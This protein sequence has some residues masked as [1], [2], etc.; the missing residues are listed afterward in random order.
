[1]KKS[2]ILLSLIMACTTQLLP[3]KVGLVLSGGGAK[4]AAHLGVIR[5]LEENNIPIDYVTGTSIGA[6]VGA[7]YATGW[8]P[9]EVLDLMLS[10][11]FG[12]WQTGK[13]EQKNWYFFK[14]PPPTPEFAKFNIQLGDSTKILNSI[15]PSSL[16]NPIQMNQAFMGLYARASEQCKEN[17]D[18]LFIPFRCMASDVFNKK[19]VVF[20]TGSL[21]DAV[22][23]SMTFPFVFKPLIINGMPMFDGGIYDNFPIQAMRDDFAPDVIIGVSLSAESIDPSKSNMYEQVEAMI[24]Q[25]TD[26]EVD[27]ISGLLLDINLPNV[28]LLDFP[29][30]REIFMAGYNKAMEVMPQIK[31]RIARRKPTQEL[32]LQRIQYRSGLHPLVFKN[33]IVKGGNEPQRRYIEQHFKE[34]KESRDDEFTYDE[35]K[36]VYFQILTDSKIKEIIPEAIYNP[37]TEAFDL[38]LN[39]TASNEIAV[40]FGGNISSS[41]A[42]QLYLGLGYQTLGRYP[43]DA[44]SNFQ[45]GN[46]FSG[47]LLTGRVDIP[48]SVPMYLRMTGAFSLRNY[49]E[50]EA[51]FFQETRPSYIRSKELYF[52]ASLGFPFL[53]TT[54]AEITAGFGRLKDRYFPV[55]IPTQYTPYDHSNYNQF[56]GSLRIINST[57][58]YKQYATQGNYNEILAQSITSWDEYKPGSITEDNPLLRGKQ[59]WLQLS[60]RFN[61]YYPMSKRF[62]LGFLVEGLLSSKNLSENYTS[63]IIQAPAFT[64]TPHSRITFNESY[65]SNQYV[66]GGVIPIINLTKTIHFRSELYA[67]L[68]IYPIQRSVDNEVTYGKVIGKMHIMSEFAVVMQLSFVTISAY[69]NTYDYPFDKWNFGLNIGYLIFNPKFHD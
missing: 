44:W 32:A 36:R 9:E 11:E 37:E 28:G 58:N 26:Y 1:M 61:N 66:A 43:F 63:S 65:R 21:G 6:V 62:T 47:V 23:A 39:V 8:S 64:P 52:K 48:G 33:V 31:E 57:L 4:G 25:K 42:N 13:V 45:V 24:M 7:M 5:A 19:P 10:E 54:K 38:V 14:A 35:F 56:L 2:L 27:S 15:L 55:S 16:I 59:S 12:H 18:S 3:Q 20:K 34:M 40:S 49:F 30:S 53:T 51:L 17:F 67:F 46:A 60:A 41:Y 69:A 29:K 22:R 50:K 68:P